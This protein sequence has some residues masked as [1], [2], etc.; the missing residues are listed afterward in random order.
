MGRAISCCCCFPRYSSSSFF[1]I[2]FRPSY[3]LLA[4]NKSSNQIVL[5]LNGCI[6]L[7]D[8][9]LLLLPFCL[10]LVVSK[11]LMRNDH[12]RRNRLDTLTFFFLPFV[13]GFLYSADRPSIAYLYIYIYLF[14]S[15]SLPHLL[16][17]FARAG[18][19][20]Y[21]VVRSTLHASTHTQL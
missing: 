16:L 13:S 20:I 10:S 18:P 1:P 11:R 19:L 17:R 12:R 7:W 4:Y 14:F 5:I 2:K 6:W 3:I 15:L 21:S 8:G 9:N